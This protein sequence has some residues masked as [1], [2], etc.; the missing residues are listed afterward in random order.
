VET[1]AREVVEE[2]GYDVRVGHRLQTVSYPLKPGVRKKVGYWSMEAIGGDFTVN[3][4]TDQ[5]RW[6][7]VDEAAGLVSYDA[8]REVLREFA[9]RP[10]RELHTFL[11]VRHAKA[12]SREDYDGDDRQ[13]PLDP[14]GRRQADALENVLVLFGAHRLHAADRLR[15]VQTLEPLAQTLRTDIALE[16]A[17]TEEA[18]ADDPDAAYERLTMIAAQDLPVR[19]VCSQ[20]GAIAPLMQRWSSDAG[21]PLPESKNRKGSVWIVTMRGETPVCIDHLPSALPGED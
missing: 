18:Y 17:L 13:R 2:T 11:L 14:R 21:I 19:V 12:G 5:V 8:D 20:G 16:P 1:A 4:E 6:L 3:H 10:V 7:S 9:T 15:C